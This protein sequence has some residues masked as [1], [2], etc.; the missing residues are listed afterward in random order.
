MR[1]AHSD[2][3]RYS[4]GDGLS[5]RAIGARNRSNAQR[6][7]ATAARPII[8]FTALGSRVLAPFGAHGVNLAAITAA[9]CTGPE[10]HTDPGRRYIAGIACG[11]FYILLGTFAATMS[12]L[13]AALPKELIA[14]LAGLA[15]L[16]AIG[17]GLTHAMAD[18][19]GRE[20]A[21]ITLLVTASGM[22]FLGLGAAFWGLVFGLI[23]HV[24]YTW[25]ISASATEAATCGIGPDYRR[26]KGR[27]VE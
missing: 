12:S 10:A 9:I 17:S 18:E 1:L 4:F 24:A 2:Q 7:Y 6:R 21:L 23:F 15:L 16:G 5:Y 22:S 19:K 11:V 13:F 26:L 14:A 8:A 27:S 3:H 25:I 20:P